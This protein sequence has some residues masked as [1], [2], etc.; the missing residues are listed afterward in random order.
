[1]AT[2]PW[3]AASLAGLQAGD[4]ILKIES[5]AL[6]VGDQAVSA[7]VKEIQ[8]S[9]EDP[10]LITIDRDGVLKDLTLVPQ[11]IDGKGTIGAQLQPNIKK[12]LKRQKTYSNFLNTP[13][14][15]FHHCW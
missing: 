5:S 3:R 8:N 13:I 6:G 9:S 2:Q 11:N 12:R 7:L 14:M 1:L 4:K 15:S 10:I